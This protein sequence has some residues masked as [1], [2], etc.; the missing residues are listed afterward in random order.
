[1]HY[2]AVSAV[3]PSGT[4]PG[5]WTITVG[6]STPHFRVPGSTVVVHN[7][8]SPNPSPINGIWIVSNVVNSTKFE[9]QMSTDPGSVT[10]L[11]SAFIGV[12]FQ[13]LSADGGKNAVVD[14]N[15]IL[16]TRFGGPYHD[17][18]TTNAL[19]VRNN[20]YRAV[21]TGLYQNLSLLSYS[22]TSDMIP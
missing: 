5:P 10:S 11:G 9:F 22:H 19:I 17:F 7:V 16:N 15:R 18:W 4:S 20:H 12:R 2:V 21:V 1:S 14:G 13:A 6:N 8:N 3:T